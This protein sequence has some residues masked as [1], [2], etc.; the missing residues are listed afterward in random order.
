MEDLELSDMRVEPCVDSHFIRPSRV[1]FKQNGCLRVWDYVREHDDVSVL[2][3]NV[4]KQAFVFVKQFRPA[5]YMDVN[6]KSHEKAAVDG[7]EVKIL[8]EDS[9]LPI[10]APASDGVTY[11]LC[12]G[13][14]DK[15]I[16]LKSL[17]KQ[18]ILE[19][20]GYDVPE[21]KIRRITSFRNGIGTVGSL[22]T[23]FFVEVEDNMQ[24]SNGGGNIDEGERIELF[25]VPVEKL[26]QFL[27]D[28]KK[29]KPAELLFAGMWW[30]DNN[31][32]S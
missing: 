1:A 17:V 3:L 24:V 2:I 31:R 29:H 16:G 11:E 23:L 30:L 10:T 9:S 5:V 18:E 26:K 14:V 15:N 13:I 21:D 22:Q 19:E 28:E 25:Y 32:R 8:E 6:R 4:S 20:C 27:M 7:S 12:S